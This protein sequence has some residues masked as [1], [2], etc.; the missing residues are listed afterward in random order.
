MIPVDRV[1]NPNPSN[2]YLIDRG[3]LLY[4]FTK[5]NLWRLVQFRRIVYVDADIVALRAPDELF[6]TK[7]DFAAASDIGWPDIFN[8]GVMVLKP[9]MGTYWA[10]QTQAASG[11]SFDG[12]DQ[13]L[14]NQYYEHKGWHRLP[15]VYNCTPSSSYQYEPAYRYYKSGL[16]MVHFIGQGK[17]WMKGRDAAQKGAGAYKELVNKW[18]AV[19]DRHYKVSVRRGHL[20]C[21]LVALTHGHRAN[22]VMRERQMSYRQ[23]SPAKPTMHMARC[24]PSNTRSSRLLRT[25]QIMPKRLPKGRSNLRRPWNRGDSKL[26]RMN[27]MRRGMRKSH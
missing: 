22:L 20:V 15:F 2:L 9:D 24:T 12:A 27:G 4:A 25:A 5:I 10:L 16:S 17:P 6:D 13:G 7:A 14:I 26:H 21:S 3:D 18:W 23:K 8:T 11:D 1:A 19:Y